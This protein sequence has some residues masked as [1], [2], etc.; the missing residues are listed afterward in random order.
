MDALSVKWI[1]IAIILI[2]YFLELFLELLNLKHFSPQIPE[3]FT[4]VYSQE[5]YSKSQEYK[6]VLTQFYLIKS[7]F[8]SLLIILMLLLNGFALIDNWA[9][10]ISNNLIIVSL[11][12]FA[13]LTFGLDLISLPFQIY[14]TF[15]IE[16]KFGFNKTT[17]KT[18]ITDKLKQWMLPLIIG[19]LLLFVITYIYYTI[20]KYFWLLAWAVIGIFQ[21]FISLF[22]T[23]IIVPLFNKLTPLETGELKDNIHKYAKKNGFYLKDI[24]IIDSSRRST[25]LNA[26]F[27]GLGKKKKIVLYDTLIEKLTNEEIVAVLAHEVG[28][29]KYKHILKGIILSFI[30]T[31]IYLYIFQILSSSQV[32]V[33]A[34]NV[35]NPNFHIALTAFSILFSP[36]EFILGTISNILSRKHEYQADEFATKTANSLAFISALKKLSVENLSNL[37]PHP[38]YVFF[39]YSHPPLLERIRKIKT[40]IGSLNSQNT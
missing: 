37:T 18:F 3:E 27:S 5:K 1:M 14:R 6:K 22:Y 8:S 36:I 16:E 28:H 21:I 13:I 7:S 39:E 26:Y 19:G 25:K 23:D 24:Y 40:N 30:I 11:I 9:Q 38:L 20:P 34:M 31:G 29:Y 35:D 15:V 17:I 12:Y 32:I 2:A 33:Q 4:D 10:N